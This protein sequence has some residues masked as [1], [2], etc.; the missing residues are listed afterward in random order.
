VIV[1]RAFPDDY[2]IV[3]EFQAS[4]AAFMNGNSLPDEI[5]SSLKHQ[6]ALLGANGVVVTLVSCSGATV[7]VSDDSGNTTEPVVLPSGDDFTCA[8]A[9]AIV[10]R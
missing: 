10:V 1:Y 2:D 7:R 4:A 5:V 6:A 8:T 3:G 9:T